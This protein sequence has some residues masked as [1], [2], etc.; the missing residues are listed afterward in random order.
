MKRLD[1]FFFAILG[2]GALWLAFLPNKRYDYH[3]ISP[4]ELLYKVNQAERY[5]ST[6]DV[7]KA[8]IGKDP[9][10]ILVDIRSPEEYTDFS[11]QGAL[12]IPFDSLLNDNYR[13]FVD[14]DVYKVVLFS[15][16]S[17]LADQAW[18]MLTRMGFEGNYVMKGGLNTWVET[19]MRPVKPAE[20]ADP[21]E[22]EKYEFRKT[23]SQFFGGGTTLSS[24]DGG[25]A[26]PPV[27]P[28]QRQT[29]GGNV[30]GCE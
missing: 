19:I 17:T 15:N 27:V 4:K 8:I 28:I 26:P 18:L 30:G 25:A 10:Y 23:A 29:G 5:V 21:S 24:D 2:I 12:N 11:L 22:F 3:E 14:Q 6:D 16:G 9:S 1:I 13:G 20:F 7:A